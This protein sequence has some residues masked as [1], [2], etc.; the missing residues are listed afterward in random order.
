MIAVRR[1]QEMRVANA[2]QQAAQAQ[3]AIA[4]A[5]ADA[6]QAR[7]EADAARAQADAAR[8]QADSDRIARQQAES[9]AA[10]APRSEDLPIAPPPPAAA[11][12]P[13]NPPIAYQQDQAYNQQQQQARMRMLQTMNTVVATRDTPRG[14]VITIID[15]GFDNGAVRSNVS[16]TLARLA[17]VL[18]QPGVHVSVEGFSDTAAGAGMAERRAEAVRDVL[19]S[20]GLNSSMMS[21]RNLADSR[22][23]TS[24]ATA[25]G[26]MQNRRVEIVVTS[27]LI[28]SQPLWDRSYNV[29]LR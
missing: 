21:T 28:G 3:D 10:A 24:N 23:L 29:T 6:E 17:P 16:D 26:R 20:R 22:L 5:H 11:P 4:K 19:A 14:L 25:E 8:A 15:S 9:Q 13:A 7:A 27:P 12:A 2:E 1:E 18:M